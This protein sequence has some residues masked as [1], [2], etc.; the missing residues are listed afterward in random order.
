MRVGHIKKDKAAQNRKSNGKAGGFMLH[1]LICDDEPSF[2]NLLK[3]SIEALPDYEKRSMV[4]HCVNEPQAV[5]K[6]MIET[7]DIV[8][9]DV[10]MDSVNGIE[11]A[12]QLR[13]VRRNFILIFV[14][15]YGEYAA[16]GYEV[17]AF[18]FLS[19]LQ[20]QEKLPRYFAQ[21]LAEC[22]RKNRVIHVF[23]EGES[24]PIRLDELIYVKTEGRVLLFCFQSS[25]MPA[26]RCRSTLQA[27]EQQLSGQ[28]FLR[29]HKSY[30]VNMQFLK[31]LQ[32]KGAVLAT[33]ES[34]PLSLHNYRAIKTKYL[35]WKG[36][37][38]WITF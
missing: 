13:A 31:S 9:L 27:L 11:F 7:A 15:N 5:S 24:L 8:F 35:E 37:A 29:I 36:S 30:L 20:L 25:Q 3:R 16:E 21:A 33:G 32:T 19:K 23:C 6:S 38:N 14:T 2:T 26:L 12:K 34:L 1:I 10:D 22:E 17:N 4:I 18:R 28:G